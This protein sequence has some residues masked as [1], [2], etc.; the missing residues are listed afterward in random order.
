MENNNK[1]VKVVAVRMPVEHMQFLK[2]N[3]KVA[4]KTAEILSRL[5]E[6]KEFVKK[7][8]TILST[9]EIFESFLENGTKEELEAFLKS[10]MKIQDDEN[11]SVQM[12]NVSPEKLKKIEEKFGDNMINTQIIREGN[13]SSNQN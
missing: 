5:L 9:P 13:I 7:F 10:C 4:E 8:Q 12:D 1:N 6:A 11:S 3:P 2:D